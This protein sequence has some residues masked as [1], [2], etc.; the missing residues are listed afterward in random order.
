[1]KRLLKLNVE[2]VKTLSTQTM[3]GPKSNWTNSGK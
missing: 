1:M 3:A 2:S